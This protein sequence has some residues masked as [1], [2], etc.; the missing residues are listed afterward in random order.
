MSQ[1]YEFGQAA[2]KYTRAPMN[3]YPP[4]TDFGAAEVYFDDGPKLG[5]GVLTI[6]DAYATAYA[7][8]GT[9]GELREYV[10]GLA[11]LL[12][13]TI[14]PCGRCGANLTDGSGDGVD[15]HGDGCP[16]AED[17]CEECGAHVADPHG[18]ECRAAA[19]AE[20]DTPDAE[21]NSTYRPLVV[22]CRA[23]LENHQRE[24]GPI[25]LGDSDRKPT[26]ANNWDGYSTEELGQ[27]FWENPDYAAYVAG[28]PAV[29]TGEEQ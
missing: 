11:A 4:E 12:G 19:D 3:Y 21:P 5:H 1:R 17:R 7:L 20:Q 6:G 18:P 26:P 25:A 28:Q 15:G 27:Y 2:G 24:H 16:V 13:L 22:T 8:E 23:A 9:P 10:A 29:W 14:A